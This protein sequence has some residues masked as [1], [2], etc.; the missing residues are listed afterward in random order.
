[1]Q[2]RLLLTAEEK[3]TAMVGAWLSFRCFVGVDF[4]D[5]LFEKA[6]CDN[7]KFVDVDFR[8]S[9]FRGANLTNTIFRRCD[10][11]GCRFSGARLAGTRFVSCAGLDQVAI[12]G[13]R[14]RGAS[15]SEEGVLSP[16]RGSGTDGTLDS[17]RGEFGTSGPTP[18]RPP[19]TMVLT[20]LE[21]RSRM[22]GAS[23]TS[24]RFAR[25]DFSDTVFVKANCANAVFLNVDLRGADFSGAL[26]TNVLFLGC[27]FGNTGFTGATV[28]QARFI[29]CT[30]LDQEAV[31]FLSDG[32][33]KLPR[34]AV[35]E[36]GHAFQR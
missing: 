28:T 16:E 20:R 33:A 35:L 13:L 22:V 17:S 14:V 32:G 10:L 8:R 3:Q 34:G 30:G 19:R 12:P 21:K 9:D 24:Q 18:I 6:R 15:V 5:T 26:L 1:M 27:E 25:V 4:S 36:G 2:E 23:L 11:S 7:A 29:A 31:R